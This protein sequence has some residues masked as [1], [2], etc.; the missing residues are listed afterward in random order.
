MS[1]FTL[2]SAATT[3]GGLISGLLLTLNQTVFAF[4]EPWHGYVT[5]ALIFG[6][7]VGISPLVGPAFRSALHLSTEVSVL[8]GA[9]LSAAGVAVTTLDISSGTKAVI[10]YDIAI[11]S[12]LGFAPAIMPAALHGTKTKP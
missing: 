9:A 12:A 5:V 3:I 6:S 4:A 7:T 8:I 11:A 10:L 1:K 2:P